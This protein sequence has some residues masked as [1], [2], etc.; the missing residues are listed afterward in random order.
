MINLYKSS[1]NPLRDADRSS[2]I[3]LTLITFGHLVVHWYTNLLSL[4]L[5]YIKTE[6]SLTDVQVGTIITVQT[7]ATT[8][9]IVIV[10]YIADSFNRQGALIVSLAI[11]SFGLSMFVLGFSS[12]YVWTLV[13]SGLIGL[14]TALWHPAAMRS[15]SL[16]FREK[17]GMALSIHGVGASIGDAIGPIIIGSVI[18]GVSWKYVLNLHLIPALIIALILW[19]SLGIMKNDKGHKT[20]LSMYLLGLKTMLADSQ[21]LGV[22]IAN[23]LV[24]MGRLSIL[25]FF[26]IYLEETLNYSAS[27]L[28]IFLGL[29]YITGIISQPI[30]G[31]LS[32]KIGRKNVLVPSFFLMGILY[33]LMG[34]VPAGWPLAIVVLGMGLFF[35]AILNLIQT[36]IMDVAPEGVQGSTMAVQGIFSLPFTLSSPVVTGFLVT[37]FGIRTSFWYAAASSF[38]AALLL[39]PIKFRKTI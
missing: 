24:Q 13:A 19:K 1:L 7:G 22:V 33:L 17:R 10:G 32:D 12:N 23:T 38:L 36:A 2:L 25:A 35:Y 8:V 27:D 15:V 30:M 31:V 16:H 39:L 4:T 26:P 21:V 29:L 5:P 6:L 14:G 34:L 37:Q 18:V 20:D 9:A 11:V 28:G 3:F